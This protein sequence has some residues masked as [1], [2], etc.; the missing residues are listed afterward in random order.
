[1]K[2]YRDWNPRQMSLLPVDPMEWL[3]ENHLVH[4]LLD[5][6]E[7]LDLSGIEDVIQGKDH[8][9]KRPF[10]PRMMVGL[11]LYGYCV[12]I[13]SSRKLETATHENVG[14]RVLC[15]GNHPDHCT[16]NTFRKTHLPQLSGLFLQVLRMCQEAGLVKLGHVALD[17][18]KMQGNASKRKAM[19]YSVMKRKEEELTAEIEELL[20]NAEA[21]DAAEDE[22]YGKDKRGDELPEELRRREGRRQKIREA[23]EVLEAQAARAHAEHKRKLAEKSAREATTS[24]AD[25]REAAER[26]VA[27]NEEKAQE[28]ASRAVEKAEKRVENAAEKAASLR[29]D[30]ETHAESCAA[31]AAS[32]KLEAARRDLEKAKTIQ[33]SS[34]PN[35]VQN[36]LPEHRVPFDKGGNPTPKAQLN[37]TD[38][39]SKIMKAGDGYLQGYNCQAAVDEESQIIVA[40]AATNQPPDQEHLRPLLDQVIDNVGVPEA[41]TADAG[42]WS[43]DNADYCESRGVD[44][45]I[46]PDRKPKSTVDD[47][48]NGSD[49]DRREKMRQKVSTES[50]KAIYARRKAVVEPVFGQTK[51]A[52]GFRRFMLRGIGQNRGEWGFLCTVHNLLKLLSARNPKTEAGCPT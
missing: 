4:L 29:S 15:G 36:A 10:P 49:S 13:F 28:S 12:R 37:F 5:V 34:E 42:Y 38:P 24:D 50:G 22:K 39:D 27:R 16:I 25:E 31:A 44:A 7:E 30:A 48:E 35:E 32:Q 33:D 11:L 17:G 47:S 18:T 41:F 46:A 14:F 26:R 52:R 9:G 23:R 8:R 19:S 43:G 51:E 3:P 45:Y 2:G 1:M 20:K 6:V 40:Q 21:V